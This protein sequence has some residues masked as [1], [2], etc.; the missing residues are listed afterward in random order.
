MMAEFKEK[1]KQRAQ[2]VLANKK[3]IET[4]QQQREK[5]AK[6]ADKYS[7]ELD[8][9]DAELKERKELNKKILENADSFM[10]SVEKRSTDRKKLLEQYYDEGNSISADTPVPAV[11]NRGTAAVPDIE[12]NGHRIIKVE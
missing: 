3:V 10:D 12:I 5:L 11:P 1:Q 4:L 8:L 7:T 6:D 9:I 2:A